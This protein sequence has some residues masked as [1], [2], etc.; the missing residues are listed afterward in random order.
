[1]MPRNDAA[2]YATRYAATQG[3]GPQMPPEMM[4]QIMPPSQPGG[5]GMGL[6]TEDRTPAPYQF[7]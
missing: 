6:K 3:Q 7:R 1:M 5:R 4:R 2:G